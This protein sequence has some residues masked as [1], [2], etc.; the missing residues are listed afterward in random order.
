MFP[1]YILAVVF[2][3]Y[4]LAA[5]FLGFGQTVGF[6]IEVGL[7]LYHLGSDWVAPWYRSATARVVF[8]AQVACGRVM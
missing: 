8:V 7:V 6:P 3:V 1:V 2:P 5:V 4:I